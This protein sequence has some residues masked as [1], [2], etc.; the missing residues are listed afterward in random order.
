VAQAIETARRLAGPFAL[1]VVCG[2]LY[3]VGEARATLLGL[4]RDPPVAL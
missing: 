4:A 2:S 1:V 3:L